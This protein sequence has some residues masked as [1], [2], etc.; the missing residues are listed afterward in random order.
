[1]WSARRS[2]G[3][4]SRVKGFSPGAYQAGNPRVFLRTEER[5]DLEVFWNSKHWELRGD[6]GLGGETPHPGQ[7]RSGGDVFL[8]GVSGWVPLSRCC[9]GLNIVLGLEHSYQDTLRGV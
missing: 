9:G 3:E 7:D 4:L 1:M 5:N 2:D 6:I 8:G